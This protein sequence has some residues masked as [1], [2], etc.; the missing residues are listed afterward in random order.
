MRILLFFLFICTATFGQSAVDEPQ[1][2]KIEAKELKA[3][4]SFTEGMK[5]YLIEDFE[6]AYAEFKK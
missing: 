4:Q 1:D 6:K 2:Q 5:L 3:E